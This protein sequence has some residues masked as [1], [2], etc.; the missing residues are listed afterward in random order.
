M[1]SSHPVT[2]LKILSQ[3]KSGSCIRSYS[4]IAIAT[5]SLLWNV[6]PPK[7]PKI[8]F[9]FC[10]PCAGPT[11]AVIITYFHSTIFKLCTIFSQATLWLCH[12]LTLLSVRVVNLYGRS[13][14]TQSHY[15]LL[16]STNFPVSLPLHINLLPEWRLLDRLLHFLLHL[17][18]VASAAFYRKVKFF[19]N[20]NVTSQGTLLY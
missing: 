9:Q 5:Y 17:T 2:C 10:L 6:Q 13:I 12:H 8:S 3:Q 14:E 4:R 15:K 18:P 11:D 7:R 1:N 20:T 16:H 19:I